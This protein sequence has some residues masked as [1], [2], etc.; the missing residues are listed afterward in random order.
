MNLPTPQIEVIWHW[1]A[2][3]IEQDGLRVFLCCLNCMSMAITVQSTIAENDAFPD[4]PGPDLL[5]ATDYALLL[6]H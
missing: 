5:T 4:E 1:Q 6:P 2:I 3:I